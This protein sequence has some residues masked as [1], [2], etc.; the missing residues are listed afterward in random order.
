MRTPFVNT[1]TPSRSSKIQK[2]VEQK[3]ADAKAGGKKL[4][5][6]NNKVQNEAVKKQTLLKEKAPSSTSKTRKS[7]FRK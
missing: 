2:K 1:Q 3:T 6:E 5:P 4:A 7:L